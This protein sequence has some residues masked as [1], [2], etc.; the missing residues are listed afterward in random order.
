MKTKEV[1]IR[2]SQRPFNKLKN[3]AATKEKTVT[4]IIEDY[5]DRL[6]TLEI[7]KNST[8]ALSQQPAV[9]ID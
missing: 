3:Y 9:D 1:H 5:I 6:P 4:Q 2:I 7:D 8:T